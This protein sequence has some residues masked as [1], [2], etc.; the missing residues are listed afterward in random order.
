MTAYADLQYRGVWLDMEGPEDDQIPLD[1]SD[2]WQFF[3]PRAGLSFH[4]NPHHKAYVSAA[5]GHREPGR[6]DIKENIKNAWV[7]AQ[8]GVDGDGVTLKPEKMVDV[9]IGYTYTSEKLSAS[10]NVY[11]MEYWDMLLE[12]GRLSNVGYAIKENVA[13]SWRRGVELAA[14]W[15]PLSWF[16]T[17]ANLTLSVNRIKDY[18]EY[19]QHVDTYD[20]WS[21][22]GRT[23][24]VSYGRTTMLMS[25][26]ATGMMRLSF[27]PLKSLILSVDGKYV[28]KQFLDNTMA[29]SRSIPAYFVSNLGV[30]YSLPLRRSLNFARDDEI[31][32]S[33][34]VNNIFN[35]MYYADG[36]CWKNIVEEDEALIDGIGVY[37]Q[38]PLN[39]MIKLSYR[40]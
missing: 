40:F 20:G 6:S 30:S 8:A 24:P 25:P 14:A 26:S 23:T 31:R 15:Q 39:Y 11:L 28:G 32:I 12:T 29:E 35:N 38:A 5:L 21:M 4:W 1:H 17:D 7:A 10:A 2:N 3:N 34:Y 9:E 37:P 19:V 27:M 22:T 13:R 16:K 33:L 18:T 36:W